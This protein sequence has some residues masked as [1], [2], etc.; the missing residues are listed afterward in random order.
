MTTSMTASSI[1][2]RANEKARAA[3]SLSFELLAVKV[4][5]D[6][7]GRVRADQSEAGSLRRHM[8]STG[9]AHLPRWQL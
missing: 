7:E 2:I 5:M 9:S 3:F 1:Q 8:Q 4:P 6:V